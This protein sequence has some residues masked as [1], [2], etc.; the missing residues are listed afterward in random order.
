MFLLL[1]TQ[2]ALAGTLCSDGWVSSSSGSGTCSHHGGIAGTSLSDQ[3]LCVDRRVY[4]PALRALQSC[5]VDQ[6][7]NVVGKKLNC[8]GYTVEVTSV[9]TPHKWVVWSTLDGVQDVHT[10]TMI[11]NSS[12]TPASN[13]PDE[14]EIVCGYIDLVYDRDCRFFRIGD[15][16]DLVQ[17]HVKLRVTPKD[18]DADGIID[19]VD[20]CANLPEDPDEFQDKD[21]CP[22]IDNDNDAIVD[23]VDSCPNA[24]E[25]GDRFEDT[26][27]CP[28]RDNDA[29]G[30]EDGVDQC[31]NDP[32]DDDG[33]MDND[34]CPDLDNDEDGVGDNQDMCPNKAE[35]KNGKDDEDGCP[36]EKLLNAS[37]PPP[38]RGVYPANAEIIKALKEANCWIR[39]GEIGF[40]RAS[41]PNT[42]INETR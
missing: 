33:Y 1:L 28:D 21:G 17:P 35:T 2:A 42:V 18:T 20:E 30:R 22:D 40:V 19:V 7:L 41:C 29:D 24:A 4:N 13:E 6:Q 27:G 10:D 31:V 14:N 39:P 38:G 16:S 11:Y 37:F 26:D 32:E 25:D 5:K 9:L 8:P 34:G 3:D 15:I 23:I 12:C 36:D